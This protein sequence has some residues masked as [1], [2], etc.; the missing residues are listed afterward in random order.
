MGNYILTGA[1]FSKNFGGLLSNELWKALYE[2]TKVKDNNF[3]KEILKKNRINGFEDALAEVRKC[4]EADTNRT[5]DYK[6]FQEII[7]EEFEKMD[8]AFACPTN[9]YIYELEKFL[10]IFDAFFTTNQDMLVERKFPNLTNSIAY[11]SSGKHSKSLYMPGLKWDDPYAFRLAS[12]QGDLLN[13]R[14]DN[15]KQY[16]DERQIG[17]ALEQNCVPYIKLHGSFKW[18]AHDQNMM[19]MGSQKRDQIASFPLLKWYYEIFEQKLYTHGSR[20]LVLGHSF[21]DPHLTKII[22]EAVEKYDLKFC[23][24][25]NSGLESLMNRL[26]DNSHYSDALFKR[27]LIELNPKPQFLQDVLNDG[28]SGESEFNRIKR[29]F[30]GKI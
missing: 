22:F 15:R 8:Q 30:L 14:G 16:P 26:K 10:T 28:A 6:V 13:S 7:Y 1:G 9:I 4:S 20:L 5:E 29:E 25:N 21:S 11:R 2:H 18:Y 17:K 12:Y 23:I 27:G 24:W 19:I 3:L